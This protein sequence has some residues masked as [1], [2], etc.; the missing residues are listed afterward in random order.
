MRRSGALITARDRLLL[1]FAARHR[2]VLASHAAVLLGTSREAAGARLRALR[3]AGMLSSERLFHGEPSYWWITRRGLSVIG[4]PLPPP[5]MDL[6]SYRHDVGLAWVALAAERGAFGQLHQVV[7]ERQMRS[8]DAVAAPASS[9]LD[10]GHESYGVRL[11]GVGPAG[12]ERLHYPDLLLITPDRRRIAVEL[13]LTTKEEPR[14]HRILAG[15]GAD[16]R[17]D[18]VLYLV[19]RPAVGRALGAS[20]ARLGIESM[21]HVQRVQWSAAQADGSGVGCAPLRSR[22]SLSTVRAGALGR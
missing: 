7:S 9:G 18:A 20:A 6:R 15:Y 13:E 21:V 14:R 11:G 22:R 1:S 16:S 8:R 5:R 10:R 2:I 3:G 4:S 19:D 12:R 17:I